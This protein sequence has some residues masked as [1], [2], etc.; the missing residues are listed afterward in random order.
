MTPLQ[1][2]A[3]RCGYDLTPRRKARH[4]NAQLAAVLARFGI[5]CVLDV[6]ANRGQY[7]ATLR[8]W[9]YRG[10]I[11]SF[12][13]LAEAHAALARRA[14]ADLG[15]QVAP[16]MAIGERDGEVAIAVSAESDMSSILPQSA[17]LRKVSP[18]SAVIGRE[19]VPLRR[20]DG[21]VGAYL[22]PD[23]R[24]FL[25]IDTQGYE[26]RVLAGAGE[27]IERLLGIQLEMSLVPIY[28]GE[29]DFRT[30]FDQLVTAGFEPYLL[31]P[32]YFERKLARQLQVDGVFMRPS[33][34]PA[35]PPD[36]ASTREEERT[37]YGG[38]V[39]LRTKLASRW[40]VA[41]LRRLG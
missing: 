11:V 25:K 33:A 41:R 35:A 9:G 6:G 12:E 26:A 16:R 31:L 7:G 39:R 32:G 28:E 3:R 19:R 15:W 40:W 18:S 37:R 23:D 22:R 10:R 27:L 20:L 24:L 5:S 2:L 14:G 38:T 21:L 29:Q 30:S 13:P 17:L 8:A 34:L 1:R 4:S 36:R